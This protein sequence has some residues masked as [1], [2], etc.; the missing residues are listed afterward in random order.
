MTSRSHLS[1]LAL[2]PGAPNQPFLSLLCLLLVGGP[3]FLLGV[4]QVLEN[5]VRAFAEHQ[6]PS[7]VFR[8]VLKKGVTEQTAEEL[9]LKWRDSGDWD[10]ATVTLA[11]DVFQNIPELEQWMGAGAN[12]LLVTTMPVTV[13]LQPA[14][15]LTGR[16]DPT[17]LAA[18]LE[19]CPEVDR[20]FFDEDGMRWLLRLERAASEV[21]LPLR[22]LFL[23][24]ALVGSL[25]A[26]IALARAASP[27]STWVAPEREPGRAAQ[28][29]AWLPVAS[30]VV[31]TTA[32]AGV[33][34]LVNAES[35]LTAIFLTTGQGFFLVFAG[36][37]LAVVTEIA[38]RFGTPRPH[39]AIQALLTALLALGAT[40]HAFPA[41][42]AATTVTAA[43]AE[44][45]APA[46]SAGDTSATLGADRSA[47]PPSTLD[48][49][50]GAAN[51]GT[52]TMRRRDELLTACRDDIDRRNKTE[53]YLRECMTRTSEERALDERNETVS[54]QKI[55]AARRDLD[56][57]QSALSQRY[58]TLRALRS[59][60]L[61]AAG[62]PTVPAG[63]LAGGAARSRR[64]VAQHLLAGGAHQALSLLDNDRDHFRDARKSV[65]ALENEERR[66][67]ILRTHARQ[68]PEEIRAEIERTRQEILALH[69]REAL[70]LAAPAAPEP[71]I[72]VQLAT[73]SARPAATPSAG[74]RVVRGATPAPYRAVPGTLALPGARGD[75]GY[76]LLCPAGSL[77]HAVREGKVL[78]A[79]PMAGLGGLVTLD[80]GTG[81]STLYGEL[82]EGEIGVQV[83]Q[84]VKAG[85]ILGTAGI[86]KGYQGRGG[87]RF[88]VRKDG[89]LVKP[90]EGLPGLTMSDLDNQLLGR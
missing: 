31:A 14:G 12:R 20:V 41:Q 22:V 36:L 81:L 55:V 29:A 34:L 64:A 23:C 30:G 48:S 3:L 74:A 77:V 7:I 44:A 17:R 80:H 35:S 56:V 83:G 66:L 54:R 62:V 70:I 79:A 33:Q 5:N 47:L 57:F 40:T 73:V 43:S 68:S 89:N 28:V 42:A 72:A 25:V 26:G 49:L 24:L 27:G 37:V 75:E 46:G 4:V 60:L 19:G 53:Q 38:R 45:A 2:A 6:S 32:L 61:D 39:F 18:S 87:V 67:E 85:E 10:A 82:E 11:D 78:H 1:L 50:T 59:G 88:E 84:T 51:L 63:D 65:T 15:L 8:V 58:D 69:A 16:A 9:A 13:D 76:L 21:G 52:L 71:P 86:V 90:A